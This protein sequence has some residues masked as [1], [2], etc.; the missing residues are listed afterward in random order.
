M[1]AC[2]YRAP[3]VLTVA[4]ALAV[5]ITCAEP[6]SPTYPKLAELEVARLH[7][8]DVPIVI[9]LG[10]S[11]LQVGER[12]RARATVDDHRLEKLL[13]QGRRI[14]FRSSDTTVA[15]VRRFHGRVSAIRAGTADIIA[16][17][18]G[19]EARVTLT[20]TN[21]TPDPDPDPDPPPPVGGI[22]DPTLLPAATG[23]RPVAGT[24]GRSLAAG[25]TYL[26]PHTNVR[27][28]KL[29]SAS[30]PDNNG[31]QYHGYSEGGPIISQPWVGTDGH[32]YYTAFIAGGWLVDIRYDT[33]VSSN[34]RRVPIDGEI[35]WA[36]SLNPATPRIAYYVD[37][38]NDRT[39]H[40]YN[41]ATNQN[42][43]S[44]IF[45]YTPRAAGSGLTWLQVNLN[46][47]WLVGMFNGNATVIAVRLSDGLERSYPT[48][49]HGGIDTDEPHIDREF[50]VVYISTNDEQNVV[51]N[52]ETN[53]VVQETDPNFVD[54]AD[55]AAPLRGKVVAIQYQVPGIVSAD[56]N[57]T[58]RIE[59]TPS[60]TDWAG[61]WHMAGQWVFNNPN[62]YFVIDQWLRDGNF[63]IRRGMIGFVSL[64]GDMRV[65]VAHDAT[66]SGYDTGGQP[67]PTLSPDGK[68]LM[69]T[70]NMN[71]SARYDIFVARIPT[72]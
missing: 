50:P 42:E 41:T 24:Y 48:S 37:D 71:G 54:A 19:V 40:R 57:G 51:V 39:I 49:F 67:H 13:D 33:F 55:H 10:D 29:T 6:V 5:A 59:V 63:P 61:D 15:T 2:S 68:L 9:T 56:R 53:T 3:R 20:V 32:T 17:L 44:G 7:D 58:V 28:L 38:G 31:G 12:T 21:S 22:V 69:W 46:D 70:S 35:N 60:P 14:K 4:T 18:G 47:Q 72:R 36:F 8:S 64:A 25:Q 43:N 52:L 1:A 34:W 11:T 66:G 26:D 45:P 65:I 62:N 16:S 27:V 23:Q 30:V